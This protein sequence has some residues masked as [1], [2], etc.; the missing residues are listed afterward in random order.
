VARQL[1]GA[2]QAGLAEP[3]SYN[4]IMTQEFMM[5]VPRSSEMAGPCAVK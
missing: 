5:M 1:L 4:A 3:V 2:C